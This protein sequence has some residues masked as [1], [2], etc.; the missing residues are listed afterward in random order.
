MATAKKTSAADRQEVCKKLIRLLKKH[1]TTALPKRDEP[2]LETILYAVCLEDSTLEQ[3]ESACQKLHS[4]FHDLNEI[5]VSSISELT[6]VLKSLSRPEFRALEIRSTLQYVFE[7]DFVFNLESLRRRTLDLAT[8]HLARIKNLSVFVRSYSLQ[9][10]LG[11]HLVPADQPMANAAAWLG[12]VKPGAGP[13][14]ATA[15][16]K[17]AVRKADVPLFCH[18]LRMLATDSRFQR[19]FAPR[20]V[21]EE[22]YDPHTALERLTELFKTGGK[23]PKKPATR[24]KSTA[25]SAGKKKSSRKKT[26]V[27]S[28]SSSRSVRKKKPAKRAGSTKKAAATRKKSVAKTKTS[29]RKTA[30]QKPAAKK[31]VSKSVSSRKTVKRSRRASSR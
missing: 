26:T 8:K 2:V 7:S 28:A 15:G 3:A 6:V 18:L 16:L 12:L 30:T 29:G 9:T 13:K 24:Q 21:P 22:G 14:E 4:A 19:A 20:N 25:R 31:K 10:V 11:A 17:S 5:R 1:Y 27:K 23:Q